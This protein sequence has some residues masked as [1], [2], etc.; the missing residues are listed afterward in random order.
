MIINLAT[1]SLLTPTVLLESLKSCL[2]CKPLYYIH[3]HVL[4]NVL[5]L[6]Y[7]V[8]YYCPKPAALFPNLTSL[9]PGDILTITKP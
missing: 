6:R 5:L 8:S 3:L 9:S 4:I 1:E 2:D 7:L